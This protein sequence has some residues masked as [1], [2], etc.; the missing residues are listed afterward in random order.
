[1]YQ[2]CNGHIFEVPRKIT[3]LDILQY[4]CPKPNC[5][6]EE[7]FAVI[8]KKQPKNSSCTGF[9]SGK[10]ERGI[11]MFIEGLNLDIEDQHLKDTPQ[12][13]V[14]AWINEFGSGY[15]YGEDKIK[16]LLSV[17]FS[18][19]YD[20]MVVVKEV[21]FLSHCSHHLVPFSGIAKIGYVPNKKVVGLSKLA[22]VLDAYALRL[23]VQERLTKQTA[24]AIFKYLEPLGVGVV[25]EAS[26]YCMCYRGVKKPGSKMVTSCLLGSMREDK[27]MR[28]EFLNF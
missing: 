28:G 8:E 25:L 26:H 5:D 24:E 13:V 4:H 18:E 12:R 16:S 20:E 7:S 1:M 2:C 3:G 22:R 6:A 15:T 17:E 9:S 21:P 19:E 10:M 27:A 23:Q 14:K 11:Q